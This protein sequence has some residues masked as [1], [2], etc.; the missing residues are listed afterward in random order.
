MKARELICCAGLLVLG[1][2]AGAA[3]S[4]RA[5][6]GVVMSR[7]NSD[8][9]TANA[10]VEIVNER[11]KWR[12][13]L[14]L[15][16]LYGR[17]AEATIATRWA[18][19]FQTD[20]K[21]GQAAY[22]FIGLGY[23]DDRFSGFDYQATLTSG[24]GR[25]FIKT[26]RTLLKAQIG[27]GYRRLRPEEL[28]FDVDSIVIDRIKGEPDS[29]MVGNGAVT[30]EHALTDSTKLLAGITAESGSSNTLTRGDLALQ[31]KMTELLAI[32][33]GLNVRNN[34]NPPAELKKTDTLTTLNLVYERK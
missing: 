12:N 29:D 26:E 24:V 4:G 30:L 10:K 3:N 18:S 9:D 25:E 13:T 6:G 19:R 20:R 8:T 34:S 7:G 2:T 15:A 17:S 28:I 21:F 1:G 23:E 31:V 11:D 16:G 22:W 32:S 14:G 27:A 33:V 5:E